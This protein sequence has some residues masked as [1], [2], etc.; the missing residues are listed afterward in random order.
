MK[1]TINIT[2]QS[3]Q[4]VGNGYM[5]VDETEH[6]LSIK[7]YDDVNEIKFFIKESTK[8]FD[9]IRDFVAEGDLLHCISRK[10]LSAAEYVWLAWVYEGG[11]GSKLTE[12]VNFDRLLR[13]AIIL[14]S[15]SLLTTIE[16]IILVK[17]GNEELLFNIPEQTIQMRTID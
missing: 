13:N 11:H 7:I 9:T 2:E 10:W 1:G 6:G 15:S 12:R 16:G 3:K 5:E 17:Y 14:G 8:D 4:F